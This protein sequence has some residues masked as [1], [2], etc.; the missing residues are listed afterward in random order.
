MCDN[1]NLNIENNFILEIDILEKNDSVS[2]S[3][4]RYFSTYHVDDWICD[5][6]NK[7]SK[8]NV[9]QQKLWML[10]KTLIICVKRFA[11]MNG[12][13]KKLNYEMDIPHTL[14]L[15]DHGLQTNVSH[16]YTLKGVINHLGS[17]YYGHYNADVV[18]DGELI[19]IDDDVIQKR[20]SLNE[21]NCYILF[22]DQ[23]V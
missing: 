18:V 16:I 4:D 10:P 14:N 17:S 11:H 19:K 21:K 1:K 3:I 13:M 5:K 6:C 23:S 22:Y 15:D 20:S 7:H 9:I 8:N 2:Q 12:K